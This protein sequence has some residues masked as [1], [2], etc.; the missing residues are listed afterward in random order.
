MPAHLHTDSSP[1]PSFSLQENE[2]DITPKD[3]AITNVFTN[4]RPILCVCVLNTL[5]FPLTMV[6]EVI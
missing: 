3:V 4:L 2:L 5:H 1:G 6:G